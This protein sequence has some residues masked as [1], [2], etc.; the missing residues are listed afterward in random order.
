MWFAIAIIG[1]FFLALVFILDKRLVTESQGKPIVYAFYSSIIMG[2]ALLAWPFFGFKLLLGS[3]WLIAAVA[4]VAFGLGM[5]TLFL[6][7]DKG[8]ATH[9]NPFNG[10]MVTIF[11]YVLASI[12][13]GEKLGTWQ[14]A[15]LIVLIVASVLLSFEK[16]TKHHGFHSG[17]IWAIVSGLFFAISHV[18]TKYLYGVYD[19]WPVLIWTRA[20]TALLGVALIISPAVRQSWQA[21]S[22][23]SQKDTRFTTEFI[24]VIDKVL[25]VLAIVL[26]QY[27]FAIGTVTV[28]GA[29]SG[30]QYA[31][32]FVLIY[33]SSKFFPKFFKEY[34]TRRELIIEV[35]AIVLVA[36]GLM[37][38]VY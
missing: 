35:I 19:F 22:K 11:I 34:F 30:L 38:M 1:Y 8:E 14:S 36:V 27:A 17:F 15:G 28:V 20:A 10:A 21:P 29:L 7:V 26:I 2:G 25:S 16:T 4:G 37:M 3:D 6:A 24:F 23:T 18:A 33:L 31:L 9:I 5:W 32:M 13:L 12:F